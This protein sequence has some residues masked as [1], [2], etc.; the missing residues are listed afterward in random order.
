MADRAPRCSGILS[1]GSWVALVTALQLG[2]L[3][4]ARGLVGARCISFVQLIVGRTRW[5]VRMHAMSQGDLRA[6]VAHTAQARS[7]AVS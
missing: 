4:A 6:R 7:A 1:L 2:C 5:Q 3:P